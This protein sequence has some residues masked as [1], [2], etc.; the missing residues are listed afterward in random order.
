M[1]RGRTN[2]YESLRRDDAPSSL[3][4]FGEP[5]YDRHNNRIKG[6]LT[7]AIGGDSKPLEEYLEKSLLLMHENNASRST[8]RVIAASGENVEMLGFKE[9]ARIPLNNGWKGYD[10]VYIAKNSPER[11]PDVETIEKEDRLIQEALKN[12]KSINYL[13]RND[14]FKFEANAIKEE[15]IKDVV[16]LYKEAYTRYTI[17]INSENVRKMLENKS[18]VIGVAR[19]EGRIVSIGIG[20][21]GNVD[22]QVDGKEKRLAICEISDAAT[23]K[24]HGGKGLYQGVLATIMPRLIGNVHLIF[25]EARASEISVNQASVNSGFDYAGRLYGHCIIGG[26]EE[27]EEKFQGNDNAYGNLNVLVYKW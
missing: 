11:M 18:A 5:Y 27:I 19:Y 12:R 22:M 13:L 15:D 14:G 3:G 7:V 4:S 26:R 24:E 21:I 1:V 16:D 10:L 9:E 23:R 2:K 20:E 6:F 8:I 25:S 17:E